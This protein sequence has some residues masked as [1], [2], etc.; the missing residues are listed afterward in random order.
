LQI[1]LREEQGGS[2]SKGEDVIERERK[3]WID[4]GEGENVLY[5]ELQK[6]RT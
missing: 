6:V 4:E 5:R 1:A 3:I 2:F